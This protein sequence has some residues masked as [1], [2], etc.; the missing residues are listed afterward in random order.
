[1][2]RI[3][4]RWREDTLRRYPHRLNRQMGRRIDFAER[5]WLALPQQQMLG[6]G[7]WVLGAGCWVLGVGGWVLKS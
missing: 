2:R 7:C 4:D 6:A 1:M 5:Q 3:M